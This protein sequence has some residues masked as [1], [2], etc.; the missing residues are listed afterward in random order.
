MITKINRTFTTRFGVAHKVLK[1]LIYVGEDNQLPVFDNDGQLLQYIESNNIRMITQGEIYTLIPEFSHLQDWVNSLP[2]WNDIK[3]TGGH[4]TLPMNFIC[5]HNGDVWKSNHPHNSWEPAVTGNNLWIRIMSA[6]F[7]DPGNLCETAQPW[8]L[9]TDWNALIV[10]EYRKHNGKIYRLTDKAWGHL[11]PDSAQ[12]SLG[13]EFI[14]D[15]NV[16]TPPDLCSSPEWD[17][18]QTWDTYVVGTHYKRFNKVYRV[19]DPQWCYL[20]PSGAN[21][22]L[23]WTFVQDCN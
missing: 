11:E 13:W 17:P 7:A 21:G 23:G 9:T 18:N 2:E 20:D 8:V 1:N 3:P 22:D 5:K 15:C 16:V 14:Q 4:N 6:S 12:G 19:K 10:G